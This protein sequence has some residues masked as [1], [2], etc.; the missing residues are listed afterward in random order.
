MWKAHGKLMWKERLE[1]FIVMKVQ[2]IFFCI[3]IPCSDVV[4][5][6]CFGGQCCFHL[7]GEEKMEAAQPSK[8]LVSYITTWCHIPEDKCGKMY[9]NLEYTYFPNRFFVPLHT[10]V[11]S[12]FTSCR[13]KSTTAK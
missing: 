9:S 7:Q 5:Y 1:I 8:T 4:G 2:V 11:A 6:Q 3:V 10:S 13:K 12:I